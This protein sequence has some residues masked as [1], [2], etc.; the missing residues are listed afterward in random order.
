MH[1][2]K[3]E[4]VNSKVVGLAAIMVGQKAH[5]GSMANGLVAASSGCYYSIAHQYQLATIVALI[6]LPAA[7]NRNGTS[8]NN[9]GSNGYYWSSSLN[10]DN[11]NNAWN[12]NF[13]SSNVNVNNNN[14]YNGYSV[15][16]VQSTCQS[17]RI[18]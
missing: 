7:G 12:L 2:D 10:S 8:L 5:S 15:R 18:M 6:F 4:L 17:H 1:T 13:N 16:A 14:R 3:L 11:P 9:Q